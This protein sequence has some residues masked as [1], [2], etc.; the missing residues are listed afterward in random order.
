MDNKSPRAPQEQTVFLSKD[1]EVY[2][3]PSLLYNGDGKQFL[4]FAEQRRTTN[5]AST[6]YLVMKT[7]TLKEETPDVKTIEWSELKL[8]KEALLEGH[9]PMNPCPV[10]E[11]TTNTLF[12][13]FICVKGTVSECWQRFW[14]CNKARLCYIT[15]T[16]A[17][18]T[19]STVTDLTDD[20]KLAKI[21][22]WATFAVGPGHGIQMQSGRLIVPL[23]GY[24]PCS[25][26]CSFIMFYSS[27]PH[28]L[29]LYSDDKGKNW[30]FSNMLQTKSVEC[31]MAEIDDNTV[32]CNARSEGGYRV[33]AMDENKGA[34]LFPL[35]PANK[36]VE[37]GGGCQGGVVSFPAEG[38]DTNPNKWLLFTHP[39]DPS[40][41]V[42]LGVYLNK[43]PRDP[44]AWST[45]WIL[46][47]GPSGYS[48][49]AYIG[50]GWFACLVECGELKETEQIAYKVFHYDD[51]K[52]A[53]GTEKKRKL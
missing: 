40:K 51:I 50:D 37:T 35:P 49:L 33:E 21:K 25:T 20:P 12:L 3:I 13:F 38:E 17:G 32:Y 44:F 52:P 10:Y 24:A 34:G 45:P 48:D 14:G 39:S 18:Q 42:N 43:S 22:T 4:A 29:Y 5:D 53:E 9:R 15:S 7:G 23:Y 16:D 11:K 26:S 46:N 1:G 27:V 8:V 6:K 2:R 31:E 30:Q 47:S 19:W 41:R 36:L 28:A